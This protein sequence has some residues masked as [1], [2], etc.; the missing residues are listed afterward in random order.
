MSD[1]T[2]YLRKFFRQI[3]KTKTL[4]EELI[5]EGRQWIRSDTP[6]GYRVFYETIRS[7]PLPYHCYDWI[8]DLYAA[9]LKRYGIEAF[10]GATKTTT[11][12]ETFAAYQIGLFPERSNLFVQYSDDKAAKHSGNVAHIIEHNPMW[13]IWFPHVVPDPHKGWGA[14]GYWAKDDSVDYGVWTQRRDGDPTLLGA[15]YGAGI[16][17][18]SHP[19]GILNIDDINTDEN[20]ESP[21]KNE[22]VNRIVTDT[23]MPMAEDVSYSVFAQTPWTEKDALALAKNMDVYLFTKTPVF[24]PAEEGEGSFIEVVKHG[25][26]IYTAWGHLTWPSRFTPELISLKYK[27]SGAIGFARMY[28]LD[29]EAAKG[30]VLKREW[31]GSYPYEDI[32]H[33]W[34]MFMG[35]DYASTQDK[36]KHKDRDYFAVVWG[37]VSPSGVLVIED[38]YRGKI[39]QAEAEKRMIGLVGQNPYLQQIGAESIG[40]GEEFVTL[41]QR[42]PI[43]MP[44]LPIP[45]HKGEAR[46]KGGRFEKVLAKMFQFGR[47]KISTK[48][49]PFIEAFLDE[50]ISWDKRQLTHDDTLD[51]VYMMA[52][53]AEGYIAVPQVQTSTAAQSPL[54]AKKKEETDPWTLLGQSR[55]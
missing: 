40:K 17:V 5:E 3:A 36:L 22:E 38:G 50:W 30:S 27:E 12:T 16:V 51:A 33:D 10:R 21:R 4:T 43:F 35:V 49:T 54:F 32:Q 53:A 34:P 29:L 55:G 13:K 9:P 31:I 44:I 47:I 20:T 26:P 19:T 28:L 37:R 46:T 2:P 25:V 48:K 15:G 11:I 1:P 24:R 14:K 45:S 6:G 41:L 52:K 8:N 42:A 23:L 39:S 18:G 7:W